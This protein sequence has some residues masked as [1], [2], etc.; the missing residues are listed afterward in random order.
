MLQA[1]KRQKRDEDEKE[2]AAMA[3]GLL[4]TVDE[5]DFSGL[6]YHP[7]TRETKGVFEVFRRLIYNFFLKTLSYQLNF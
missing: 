3:T 5:S 2:L 1:A 7:K 4:S 6:T